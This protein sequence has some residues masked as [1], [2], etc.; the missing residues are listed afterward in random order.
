MK[1]LSIR[2][3][4][5]W[6]IVHG[7]KNIENRTWRTKFRGPVLIHAGKKIDLRAYSE[8]K[9]QGVKLPPLEK[10]QTGG[11]IGKVEIVDCVDDSASPWFRGP[12]GFV[13]ANP[14]PVKFTPCLGKLYFFEFDHTFRP[15][16]NS[17][18]CLQA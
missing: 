5:A 11:I 2:Q 13:L 6:L 10:L 14:K 3:P 12:F 8:L 15:S 1:A 7:G 16:G 17:L 9:A 18:Q 4:W